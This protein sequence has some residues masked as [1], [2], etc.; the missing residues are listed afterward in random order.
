MDQYMGVVRSTFQNRSA[1]S[2]TGASS[3]HL[4][5]AM[6]WDVS[7]ACLAKG[8]ANSTLEAT[9]SGFPEMKAVRHQI[10]W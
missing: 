3:Q 10:F 4:A 7:L 9:G 5:M 2:L 1:R 6:L 8:L